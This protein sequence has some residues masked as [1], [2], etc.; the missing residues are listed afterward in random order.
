M[1]FRSVAFV[2]QFATQVQVST[3]RVW[4]FNAASRAIALRLQQECVG[5]PADSV[6]VSTYFADQPSMEFYRTQLGLTCLRPMER[7]DDPNVAGYD[8]Y[9][10]NPEKP[11]PERETLF[12]DPRTGSALAR[13][14]RAGTVIQ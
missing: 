3:F 6:R 1:L 12:R 7:L 10:V 9:V 2:L 5:K 11:G 14:E 8:Y 4:P 13:A